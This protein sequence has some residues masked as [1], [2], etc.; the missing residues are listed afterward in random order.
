MKYKIEQHADCYM[1]FSKSWY[2]TKW[3]YQ[4]SCDDIQE[5]IYFIR[6]TGSNTFS[7]YICS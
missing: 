5:A 6:S 2:S 3:K 1:I 7:F 4:A